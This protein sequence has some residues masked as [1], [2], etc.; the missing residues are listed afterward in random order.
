M[1]DDQQHQFVHESAYAI[2]GATPRGRNAPAKRDVAGIVGEAVR[3]PR[4]CR[5]VATPQAPRCLFGLNASQL[6]LWRKRLER[7][8]KSKV[9]TLRNGV[10]R[11]QR[12]D[13]PVLIATVASYPGPADQTDRN[14]VKWRRL[15]IEWAKYKYGARLVSVLEHVDEPYGH[16]HI[17]AAD[18]GNPVKPLMAGHAASDRAGAVGATSREQRQAYDDAY[19][20]WQDEFHEMVGAPCGL[21]RISAAPKPRLS[22]RKHKAKQLEEAKRDEEEALIA[23]EARRAAAAQ[24]LKAAAYVKRLVEQHVERDEPDELLA[25]QGTDSVAPDDDRRPRRPTR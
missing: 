15:V 2:R 10:R 20:A 14:Y 17:F 3:K 19:R 9:V 7:L 22:Y 16:V 5:H 4:F 11:R 24:A 6:Q 13:T 25:P 12:I 21:T 8:A 1:E 23:D 18:H